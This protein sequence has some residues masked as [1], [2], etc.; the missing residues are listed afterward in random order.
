VANSAL[1]RADVASLDQPNSESTS[2]QRSTRLRALNGVLATVRAKWGQ[3]SIVRLDAHLRELGTEDEREEEPGERSND[4]GIW[5][6]WGLG[7]GV[8]KS[9]SRRAATPSRPAPRTTPQTRPPWWPVVLP[10]GAVIRPHVLEVV[11]E[12]GYGRLTLALSWLAAAQPTIAA[13]VDRNFYPPA[14][15]AAGI[16]LD[17]LLIVYPP[18]DPSDKQEQL[19]WLRKSEGSEREHGAEREERRTKPSVLSIDPEVFA[20]QTA[21]LKRQTAPGRAAFDAVAILL[22]SEAFDAVVC[23]LPSRARL[24]LAFAGKLATLA[25]RSGTSLLLLTTP[26]RA[27]K[28]TRV[29]SPRE[30][31]FVA[32]FTSI[33]GGRDT[34][35]GTPNDPDTSY[36]SKSSDPGLLGALADYRIRL[37]SHRWHW[38][39]NQLAG[40]TLRVIT[41]RAR[42]GDID[43]SETSST[44]TIPMVEYG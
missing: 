5:K 34:T 6:Q 26:R 24:S 25:T 1:A 7:K 22:R 32:P 9:A 3:G 23:A 15:A 41:E 27:A 16:S 11:A 17:R 37:T 30:K 10:D 43:Q 31:R 39:H 18:K 36:S 40:L 35:A 13:I 28:T 44:L 2:E 12:P 38:E 14:A 42:T 33:P 29:Q 20:M 8:A 21:M 4:E 19:S